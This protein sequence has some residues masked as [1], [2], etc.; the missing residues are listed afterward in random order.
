MCYGAKCSKAIALG[1]KLVGMV[2]CSGSGFFFNGFLSEVLNYNLEPLSILIFS[3][4]S[5]L[6]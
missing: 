6:S 5:S 3:R 4:G 1:E 2:G